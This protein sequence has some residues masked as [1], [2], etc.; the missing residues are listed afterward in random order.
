M[1]LSL[2]TF[3][4]LSQKNSLNL[5]LSNILGYN[6]EIYKYLRMQNRNIVFNFKLHVDARKC[7]FVSK[8]LPKQDNY[9]P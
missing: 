4:S 2:F 7:P 8:W 3:Y 1:P 9:P 5:K 6:I